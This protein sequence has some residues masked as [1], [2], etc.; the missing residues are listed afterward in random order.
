[1]Y[2]TNITSIPSSMALFEGEKYSLE[3]IFGIF[4]K[5]EKIIATSFNTNDDNVISEETIHLS[6]FNLFDVKDVNITVIKN[7]KVIPL[8]KY[9]RFKAIF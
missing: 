9:N 6:F 1:M 3:T 8:R 7:T 4:Q 5:R 2:V